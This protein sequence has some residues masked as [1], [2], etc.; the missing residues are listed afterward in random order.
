MRQP[1]RMKVC[2]LNAGADEKKDG[3][4]DGKQKVSAHIGRP[5]LPHVW[6]RYQLLYASSAES[7]SLRCAGIDAVDTTA[8][9]MRAARLLIPRV[10]GILEKHVP[11]GEEIAS[12]QRSLIE[13]LRWNV[14]VLRCLLTYTVCALL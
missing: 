8:F 12:E 13:G 1:I 5:I 7:L 4:D 6:H 3:A 10:R 14:C 11:E 2:L 9:T